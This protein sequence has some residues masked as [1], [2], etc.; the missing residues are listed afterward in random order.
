MATWWSST[1][2]C[3]SDVSPA[4]LALAVASGLCVVCV[5]WFGFCFPLFY[6]Q[7]PETFWTSFSRDT[8]L[9]DRQCFMLARLRE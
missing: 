3:A 7:V 6:L 2:E 8:V 1:Y 9:D 5:W 4:S